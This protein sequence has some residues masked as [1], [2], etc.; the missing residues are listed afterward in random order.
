MLRN[1][2]KNWPKTRFQIFT[3]C[4]GNFSNNTIIALSSKISE[5]YFVFAT[6]VQNDYSRSY[7]CLKLPFYERLVA[8]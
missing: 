1:S 6:F 7:S 5:E 8:F 4:L 3:A 2:K